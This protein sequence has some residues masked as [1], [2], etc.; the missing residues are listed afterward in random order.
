MKHLLKQII[1]PFIITLLTRLLFKRKVSWKG[2]YLSWDI[3]K[4]HCKGYESPEIFNKVMVSALKV[5]NGEAPY[6]RDGFIFDKIQINWSLLAILQEII[7]LKHKL[8]IIDFGGSLGSV[9]FQHG[10]LHDYIINWT[11]IEQKHYVDFGNSYL[12]DKKLHFLSA[13]NEATSICSY[14]IAIFSG[15]LQYIENP[16][17]VL[18]ESIETGIEY[19]LLDRTAFLQYSGHEEFV[20]CQFVPAAIVKSSYP[21]WVLNKDKLASLLLLNGYVQLYEFNSFC[22][23][24]EYYIG[25]VPICWKGLLFQK[26]K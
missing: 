8:K 12:A 5:K 13:I 6:E 3:A 1:P 23:P 25:T 10:T 14:D 4:H 17:S 26:Q 15:V 20:C 16:Y 19:I 9:Y 22:D 24:A 7:L 18:G 21:M 11:V 2:N